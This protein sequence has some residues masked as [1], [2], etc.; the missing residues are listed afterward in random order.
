MVICP[1]RGSYTKEELGYLSQARPLVDDFLTDIDRR[2]R[3]DGEPSITEL[4]SATKF[5]V[6]L[7]TKGEHASTLIYA[8]SY[9][10]FARLTQTEQGQEEYEVV[11][12]TGNSM[13]WYIALALGGSLAWA[14][15]YSLIQG[16]GSMMRDKLV[17]GQIIYPVCDE[18]WQIQPHVEDEIR[19][20][21]E[22]TNSLPE[23]KAYLSIRL[24]GYWVLGAN[25]LGAKHLL[26]TLP[27][28]DNYPF[29]L[30]NHGAFHTPLMEAI[31]AQ[32]FQRFS[33]D[34]FKAPQVPLIDGRGQIW[35]PWSCQ[36]EDLY[37]Y[38]LGHQVIK[39]YD[40]SQAVSVALKE[41]GPDHLV[42]LGP[43]GSLGGAIGQILVANRWQSMSN[44]SEFQE[45]QSKDP[46]LI[47][48]GRREKSNSG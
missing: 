14:E 16:M 3:E 15:A 41:Y 6:N 37:D 38:T 22:Q 20:L 40:F 2:R 36:T 26:K 28:K 1:G 31:S 46:F 39:P 33:T 23:H 30:V 21:L 8:C 12:I 17:G 27:P 13:G 44:K 47:S 9:Y 29:Q 48:L 19:L 4:D 43:G 24:G 45:R 32:A 42:L 10:D 5:Q 18:N 25:A 7:H 35:K 11:A 34:I